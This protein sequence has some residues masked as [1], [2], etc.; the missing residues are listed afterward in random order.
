MS[1]YR[2][3]ILLRDFIHHHLYDASSGYFAK[4]VNIGGED[5]QGLPEPLNFNNILDESDY[6]LKIKQLYKTGPL[7]FVD[8]P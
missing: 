1:S 2:D 6:R 5:N 7:M 4:H 3:P 8:L